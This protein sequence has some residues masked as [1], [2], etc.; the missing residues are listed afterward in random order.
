[1]RQNVMPVTRFVRV[2]DE[3]QI[4][5]TRRGAANVPFAQQAAG[6]IVEKLSAPR[7]AIDTDSAAHHSRRDGSPRGLNGNAG[8][9]H[10]PVLLRLPPQL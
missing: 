10:R 7:A 8:D 5:H 6:L 2:R 1:M 9:R 3:R 4:L